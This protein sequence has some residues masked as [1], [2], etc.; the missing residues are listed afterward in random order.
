MDSLINLDKSIFFFLNSFHSSFWDV[1]MS[2][3]TRTEYWLLLFIAIIYTIIK[4]FKT[5]TII[6]L[7]MIALVILVAD[8]F[9]G[10]I[11]DLVGRLRPTHD[12]S[13]QDMVHWVKRKG[14]TF[15]FFSAHASNTFGVAMYLSL[16]FKNKGFSFLIF[17]WALIASYTR[18][19]LGLHFPSDIITGMAF[20]IILGWSVY[21]MN[22][23]L[24]NR[25]FALKLPKVQKARIERNDFSTLLLVFSIL[26]VSTF[27][28]VKGL[29]KAGLISF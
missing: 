14:G 9:S 17:S 7:V 13:M 4:R 1:V 19:Y 29:L 26:I 11:K 5:K 12:P 24:D 25:Y 27:L 6:I 22:I 10:L 15:S 3:F 23:W 18:I 20:G 28:I 8:Q 21:R 2:L 16:L